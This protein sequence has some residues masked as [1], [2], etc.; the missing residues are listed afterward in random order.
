VGPSTPFHFD[1]LAQLAKIPARITLYELLKLSKAT[2]DALREALVD[3]EIFITQSPA[4]CGERE[5]RHCYHTL[6]QFFCITFTPE[7][8][9]IK[10]KH[11]RPQYYTG[12]IESSEVSCI[13]VDLRSALRIML[14][15]FMQHLGIPTH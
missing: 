14:C 6:K 8:M 7:D 10:E 4:R 12:Y 13:Q 11:D 3:A 9:Q 15:R 5:D 1:V 2:R